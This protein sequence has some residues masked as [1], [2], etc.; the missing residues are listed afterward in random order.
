MLKDNIEYQCSPAWECGLV[1]RHTASSPHHTGMHSWHA[2]LHTTAGILHA[3]RHTTAGI[4]HAGLH[5]NAGILHPGIERLLAG[6]EP[7]VW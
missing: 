7:A 5:T 6:H 3:G 4:L 1:R 2:G